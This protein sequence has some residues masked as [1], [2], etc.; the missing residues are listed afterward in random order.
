MG[1]SSLFSF[2]SGVVLS[3][4]SGCCSLSNSP[5]SSSSSNS[6]LT[7]HSLENSCN[8][9]TATSGN[10]M[11][12]NAPSNLED[13][14]NSA[15]YQLN[16]SLL[17]EVN[18]DLEDD[19]VM[20]NS[21]SDTTNQT[22]ANL[23]TSESI[24]NDNSENGQ[25]IMLEN[26][27][28]QHP[29]QST[30]DNSCL[31]NEDARTLQLAVELTMMNLNK[32]PSP[33]SEAH[34]SLSPTSNHYQQLQSHHLQ[35]GA[36]DHHQPYSSSSS[37]T[38][39]GNPY[40]MTTKV[41]LQTQS[42]A[43]ATL[44]NQKFLSE[45]NQDVIP[46]KINSLSAPNQNMATVTPTTTDD[47]SKKSQ[48]MTECVPVPS[49]E[50]VAEIVGRQGCKIKA[51]RAKTNTYI[52]TP[53]RN[54]E[55]VFVVTGR[56]EDV[57]KAKREILS[58][59]EHFTLI[60]AT[61]RT[62][63]GMNG[64]SA[65][66]T[67]GG[68]GVNGG[69]LVSLNKNSLSSNTPLPGQITIQVR[70]PYRVVGLV[71]GPKGNTIKHIQHET[72]TYIV[73]PSRDK[74]PIFEVTGMPDNV[75]MARKQIEAHIAKRT[76]NS[77]AVPAPPP[78]PP[79]PPAPAG[80]IN[81][82]NE[83]ITSNQN[84]A[85]HSLNSLNQMLN[86]DL[87]SEILSSIYKNGI[88][89]ALEYSQIGGGSLLN[90][91]N[92][93]NTSNSFNNGFVNNEINPNII[94][95][96]DIQR[97]VSMNSGNSN[98]GNMQLNCNDFINN[99]IESNTTTQF[100]NEQNTHFPQIANNASTIR[101][102]KSVINTINLLENTNN[103][104][105][106]LLQ[107]QNNLATNALLTRSCSS[108]SSTASS[109]KSFNNSG[110]NNNTQFW[111][112]LNGGSSLGAA[113]NGTCGGTGNN[114]NIDIDEGIGESPL[115]S[116]G[117]PNTLAAITNS[118]CSPTSTSISPTDSLF[119]EHINNKTTILQQQ[120][121]QLKISSKTKLLEKLKRKNCWMCHEK[122]IVAALIPCGHTIFCSLCANRLCQQNDA[123]CPVCST[124]I[125]QAIRVH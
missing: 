51:L 43:A 85:F 80:S 56:K 7:S 67:G 10:Q 123:S 11:C 125:Y 55:P 4:S 57:T 17:A 18:G 98:N 1:S 72:K 71:V 89:S 115:Y 9:L 105:G 75:Q 44:L 106:G 27:H 34:P 45:P 114:D 70:V 53:V 61:R 83:P 28:H 64:C 36:L 13:S 63:D 2:E 94:S 112:S 15:T 104:A 93:C 50:H 33:T 14:F 24:H 102:L 113:T 65:S 6:Y 116:W 46:S 100:V 95:V 74:E 38:S 77:L 37:Y 58:A 108:A 40:H 92:K 82:I 84:T 111:K 21:L 120:Q 3:G 99:I 62:N 42:Q 118:Y 20:T 110:N 60:R 32:M 96:N 119:G 12:L 5:S 68:S 97:R 124:Q 19:H 35:H 79:P 8:K 66:L 121:Q 52:K 59:A 48:N 73:T 107:Q 81:H 103:G 88:G 31:N 22:E 90:S 69:H 39:V 41:F 54:E 26:M 78:P 122:D 25:R 29:Q 101:N 49:S 117:L 30:G 91:A 47:R 16:A 86:D 87:H 23:H 76:G 109:S